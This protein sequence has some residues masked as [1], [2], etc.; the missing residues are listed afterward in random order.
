MDLE[1][2]VLLINIGAT[3]VN[4]NIELMHIR[5]LKY[6]F[7]PTQVVFPCFWER[8]SGPR[9]MSPSFLFLYLYSHFVIKKYN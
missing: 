3:I 8:I 5:D 2:R 4:N 1:G 7:G 6:V 9:K